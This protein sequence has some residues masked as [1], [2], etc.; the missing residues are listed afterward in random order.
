MNDARLVSW[1]VPALLSD[2]SDPR[3]KSRR[4]HH[5]E[6]LAHVDEKPQVKKPGA[7]RPKADRGKAPADK[8][9]T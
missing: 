6:F 8:P 3:A 1:N 7:E 5:Q 2:S 9:R 4:R